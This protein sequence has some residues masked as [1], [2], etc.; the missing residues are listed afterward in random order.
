[1]DNHSASDQYELSIVITVV[2]GA[3]H[4]AG[5]LDALAGQQQCDPALLEI[6]VPYDAE[7]P[8]IQNLEAACPHVRFHPV[9]LTVS[10]PRG[11]CHE[12]F[13]ELRAAGLRIARGR[14]IAMLED[15]ERPD[16][17]WCRKLLDIHGLPYAAVG[18]AVEN[19]VDRALNWATWFMDFGRYQNPVSEGPSAFL[20]DVNIAYKRAPLMAVRHAWEQGYSEPDV[21]G[22]LLARG[23]TL[24][25]SPDI[26]VFQHRTGLTLARAMRER[27]VWGRFFAGNRVRGRSLAARLAWSAACLAVPGI[28]LLKKTRD[29][30]RK[31][32]RRKEFIQA[33]PLLVLL[34]TGWAWGELTGYLTGK[35]STYGRAEDR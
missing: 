21:H 31:K 8:D 18:G 35:A 15:H 32:R 25:L 24:W 1:M 9:R 6:I 17:L 28:I 22:A 5:C 30:V 11:L 16:A 23:E 20:T 29:V 3:E 7:D 34:A 10:G 19:D 2:S 33:L 4:L 12:H 13:D 26:I 14:L 27:Y